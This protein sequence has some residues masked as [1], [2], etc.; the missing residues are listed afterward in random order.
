MDE[1]EQNRKRIMA[2]LEIIKR[3]NERIKELEK[4]MND[5]SDFISLK[6]L[7]HHHLAWDTEEE[8]ASITEEQRAA[9]LL[10]LRKRITLADAK[11]EV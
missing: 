11:D 8:R 5:Y 4:A 7:K 2:A 10:W 3:K 6:E 1:L 9:G